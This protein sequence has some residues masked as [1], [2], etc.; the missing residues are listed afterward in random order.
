MG[1]KVG[2]K[3]INYLSSSARV[4]QC[5]RIGKTLDSLDDVVKEQIA[6]KS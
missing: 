4:F 1:V 2:T 6:G 5:K 3:T